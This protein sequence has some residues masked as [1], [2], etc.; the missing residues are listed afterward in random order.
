MIISMNAVRREDAR[1][2]AKLWHQEGNL[3]GYKGWNVVIRTSWF[4]AEHADS[5]NILLKLFYTVDDHGKEITADIEVR[6]F[7]VKAGL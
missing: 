2:I 1:E 4:E 5:G 6:D 3:I 7:S